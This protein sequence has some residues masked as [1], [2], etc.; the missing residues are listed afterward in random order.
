MSLAL[1]LTRAVWFWGNAGEGD[2]ARDAGL[3][4]LLKATAQL[5]YAILFLWLSMC[6]TV[7]S[8]DG[9]YKFAHVLACMW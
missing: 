3:P 8:C 2:G 4:V 6:A 7:S 9:M 5:L 1:Y